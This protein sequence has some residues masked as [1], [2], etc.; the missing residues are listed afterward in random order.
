[1]K[2][3]SDLMMSIFH[4]AMYNKN[5]K[6]AEIDV[7][8]ENGCLMLFLNAF[9]HQCQITLHSLIVSLFSGMSIDESICHEIVRKSA[10][11]VMN[12]AQLFESLLISYLYTEIDVTHLPSLVG[13]D[14]FITVMILLTAEMS[15][16]NKMSLETAMGRYRESQKLSAVKVILN[17]LDTLQS[18]WKALQHPVSKVSVKQ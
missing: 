15:C 12:H 2:T 5:Q 1:M 13:Y 18:Y 8:S 9:F 11:S 17:L 6:T 7:C 14:A 16:Q 4:T 3:L 10:E